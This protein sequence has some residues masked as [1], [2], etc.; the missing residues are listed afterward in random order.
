MNTDFLTLTRNHQKG[1][2]LRYYAEVTKSWFNLT[3]KLSCSAWLD[4]KVVTV[5]F[6]S[7]D[8][9]EVEKVLRMQNKN[10]FMLV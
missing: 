3:I 1:S 2:K 9:Q 10:A 6:S 5:M 7:F 8:P 4:S